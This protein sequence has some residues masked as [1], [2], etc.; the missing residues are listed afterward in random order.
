MR[1]RGDH[2][3]AIVESALDRY[4]LGV[5]RKLEEDLV[6]TPRPRRDPAPE[7]DAFRLTLTTGPDAGL[8]FV[9]EGDARLLVGQSARCDVQLHDREASRRHAALDVKD[10]RLY[11]ADLG[12]KN[13]TFANGIGISEVHLH[14]GETLR[15]G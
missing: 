15:L 13:G 11:V 14:G 6:T 5:A 10:G 3:S 8:S 4:P 9:V 7:R 2:P 1:D 12:S